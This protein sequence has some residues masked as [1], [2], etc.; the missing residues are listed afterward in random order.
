MLSLTALALLGLR[1]VA[2]QNGTSSASATDI[3]DVEANFQGAQLVPELLPTFSPEGTL[4]L[5]FGGQAVSIGQNLTQD[6]VASYPSITVSPASGASGIDTT[7]TYTLMM[8][9]ANPVGTDEST[10]AQTRHWLVNSVTLEGSAPYSVN[11]T[12]STAITNYAGPGP[13]AGSGSH[14]Y[15]VL[16]YSQ[17]S[18]FA[19]PANLS[20]ANTPLGTFFLE[21][22]VN[23]TGLGAVVAANYFQV[24]NGVATTS[25]PATSTVNT[26]T[27]SAAS[28]SGTGAS[29]S[30][31]GASGSASKSGSATSGAAASSTSKAAA[32][33]QASTNGLGW[34]VVVGA[35]GVV[36]CLFGAGL[37]L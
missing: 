12:G 34:G 5:T 4:D 7:S 14:R 19:A 33:M 1:L 16:L 27:L 36:G 8:V 9:D 17:P 13:A 24:E 28:V 25:V 31:S 6:A 20:T 2:A 29:A 3:A 10:T 37:G 32:G 15:V 26:A 35:V 22:Y 30:G 23:S 11:Y 18:S 21:E